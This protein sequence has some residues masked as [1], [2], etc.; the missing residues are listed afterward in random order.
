VY[1]GFEDLAVWKRSMDL[2]KEIISLFQQEFSKFHPLADQITRSAISIP[3]NI[4]EGCERGSNPDF[5]RFL[6]ISRG[7][8]AEL[9]TQLELLKSYTT[10][11]SFSQ[12][13][14]LISESQE[15]SKMI[16]GLIKSLKTQLNS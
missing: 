7:S 2:A 8:C 4:A 15:V 16:Y 12:I 1:R 3:S 10:K 13:D 6:Y 5:I 9:R 11:E 14:K